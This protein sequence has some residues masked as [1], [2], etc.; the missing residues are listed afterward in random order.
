[1]WA[2]ADE[3]DGMPDV[4]R[5]VRLSYLRGVQAGLEGR[6]LPSYSLPLQVGDLVHYRTLYPVRLAPK[7]FRSWRYPV[8]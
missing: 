6:A 8:T 7:P 5:A 2:Y 4:E 1:M 3:W